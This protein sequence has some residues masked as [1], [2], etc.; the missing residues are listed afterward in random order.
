MHHFHQVI[1]EIF[2]GAEDRSAVV[3]PKLVK[4]D[5]FSCLETELFDDVFFN[6]NFEG[7]SVRIDLLWLFFGRCESLAFVLG[8]S[9][10]DQ[11]LDELVPDEGL[12]GYQLEKL[13]LRSA[14]SHLGHLRSDLD[15]RIG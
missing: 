12:S 5:F 11:D 9:Y 1:D 7:A 10:T 2:I 13:S 8:A 14:C 4:A 15:V 6:E 3:P